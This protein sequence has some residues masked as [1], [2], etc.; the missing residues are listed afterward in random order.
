VDRLFAT[1]VGE[2]DVLGLNRHG[3]WAPLRLESRP[4]AAALYPD[5]G[6]EERRAKSR[7]RANARQPK[8]QGGAGDCNAGPKSGDVAFRSVERLDDH[9]RGCCGFAP[10]S[11]GLGRQRVV[12]I[13]AEDACLVSD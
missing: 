10:Y 2:P 3:S 5:V 7:F 12:A 11:R 6:I 4:P 13:P 9:A 1:L 8:R